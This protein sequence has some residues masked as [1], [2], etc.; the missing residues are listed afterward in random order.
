MAENTKTPPNR[1]P[2]NDPSK[3]QKPG[4]AMPTSAPGRQGVN[5]PQKPEIDPDRDR[6]R[7]P[8][9]PGKEGVGDVEDLDD[10]EESTARME[11]E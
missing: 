11:R 3:Q 9:T 7:K 6:Q 10:D 5:N 4:G 1:T 8:M 2:Q